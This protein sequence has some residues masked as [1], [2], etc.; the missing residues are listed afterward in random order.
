MSPTGHTGTDI[1]FYAIVVV[2]V[3]VM[4]ISMRFP[5]G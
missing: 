2:I 3:L 5:R 1:L 4:T